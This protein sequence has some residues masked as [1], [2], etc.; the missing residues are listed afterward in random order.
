MN[1]L[2]VHEL[3]PFLEA[4]AGRQTL[5]LDVREDWE[6]ALAPLQLPGAETRHIPMGDIPARRAELSTSQP[7]IAFCHHGM[8][9]AQ[10]VAFL[11][12]HGHPEV[13]NLAGG[14]HAWSTLVDPSVPCY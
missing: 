13:Y 7:V 11:S 5:L 1:A 3:K 2:H 8:R 6:V 10:V 4:Q 14:T 12:Q 9:S